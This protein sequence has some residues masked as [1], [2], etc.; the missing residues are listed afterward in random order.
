MIFGAI[1]ADLS[2]KWRKHGLFLFTFGI[3]A[4]LLEVP[5]FVV[6]KLMPT[7]YDPVVTLMGGRETRDELRA[8]WGLDGE[9]LRDQPKDTMTYGYVGESS[10]ASVTLPEGEMIRWIFPETMYWDPKLPAP[11]GTADF[12]ITLAHTITTWSTKVIASTRDAK[13]GVGYGSILVFKEFFIEPDV[14][15]WVTQDDEITLRVAVFNYVEEEVN[16]ILTLQRDDWF[17]LMDNA[18]K[19]TILSPNSVS[20]VEWRIKVLKPGLHT[21]TVFGSANDSFDAVRKQMRVVPNGLLVEQTFNGETSKP[22]KYWVTI[23]PEAMNDSTVAVVKISP[24]LIAPLITGLDALLGYPYGCVEQTSSKLIPDVLV[25]KYLD[26]IKR[27]TPE[28]RAKLDS[29]IQTGIQRLLYLQHY[30]GS[31]G[32]WKDD[33]PNIGMSAWVLNTW[34]DAASTGFY[35]DETAMQALQNWLL[36]NQLSNGSWPN[37]GWLQHGYYSLTKLGMTSYV[38]RSLLKSGMPINDPKIASAI[39]YVSNALKTAPFTDP[40]E[41][42][43]AVIVL[44]LAGFSSDKPEIARALDGL[45]SNAIISNDGVHWRRGSAFAGETEST[46]YVAMAFIYSGYRLDLVEGA[47]KWLLNKRGSWGGLGTTSDTCAFLTLLVLMAERSAEEIDTVVSILINEETVYSLHIDK[48][49]YDVTQIVEVS[50][51]LNVGN[52]SLQVTS[53][54]KGMINFQVTAKQWLRAQLNATIETPT[55]QA[56]RGEIFRVGVQLTPPE[57]AVVPCN[58]YVKGPSSIIENGSVVLRAVGG[59]VWGTNVL[60]EGETAYLYYQALQEG[61]YTLGPFIVSYGLALDGMFGGNLLSEAGSPGVT[62]EDALFEAPTIRASKTIITQSGHPVTVTG[63]S[64]LMSLNIT[65]LSYENIANIT[66][67]DRLLTGFTFGGL[68][69]PKS[70]NLT[71]LGNELTFKISELGAGEIYNIKYVA[72]PLMTGEF[73]IPGCLICDENH[74]PIAASEPSSLT[75]EKEGILIHRSLNSTHLQVNDIAEMNVTIFYI[76]GYGS[77]QWIIVDIPIPPGFEFVVESLDGVVQEQPH[78]VRYDIV[79]IR[80]VAFIIEA[81]EPGD[82]ITFTI[83]IEVT[84]RIRATLPA[85]TVTAMYATDVFGKTTAET[86]TSRYGDGN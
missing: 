75:V 30:D 33:A 36:A 20:K 8:A 62:V 83:E 68:I 4:L 23:Y 58:V 44:H 35:I 32:W 6:P 69:T 29:Y 34:S 2:G 31:F 56:R 43:L 41:I 25:Y 64:V 84:S 45:A 42:A 27:L 70:A 11:D 28:N 22:E 50:H 81:M 74:A 37:T 13:I 21:V 14:P 18:S 49:N 77:I 7:P 26:Q 67:T 40:Y 9:I 65:N 72:F 15:L 16:A 48:N 79:E 78:V 54:G 24:G 17:E 39:Q 73:F 38:L 80:R 85:A 52:N 61:N 10:K 3:V 53:N 46:A 51:Y 47:V 55:V 57:S 82:M 66:V 12:N 63:S 5:I 1:L 59:N 71:M 76:G 86:V 60:R 19:T